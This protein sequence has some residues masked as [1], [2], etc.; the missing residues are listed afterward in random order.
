MDGTSI[1]LAIMTAI[2]AL[3]AYWHLSLGRLPITAV[4]FFNILL[5]ILAVGLIREGIR[6]SKRHIFWGGMVLLTMQ[7][8]SRMLEYETELIFKAI[9]LLLCGFGVIAAGLWF[10]RSVRIKR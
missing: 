5:F 9:V 3:I 4:L 2:S 1:T 7:I 6:D 10:E 8:F